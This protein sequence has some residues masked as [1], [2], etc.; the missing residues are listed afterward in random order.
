MAVVENAIQI[1]ELEPLVSES[2]QLNYI[3]AQ[4]I[5]NLITS[6]RQQQYGAG[7][8]QTAT[9]GGQGSIISKRGVAIIEW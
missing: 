6:N 3:K 8:G 9:T 2:F 4:D 7:A 1:G 5:L